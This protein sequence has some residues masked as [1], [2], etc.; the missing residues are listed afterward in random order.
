MKHH[1]GN[2]RGVHIAVRIAGIGITGIVE[3]GGGHIISWSRIR[4]LLYDGASAGLAILGDQRPPVSAMPRVVQR[5]KSELVLRM[6]SAERAVRI[7]RHAGLVEKTRHPR[8]SGPENDAL[9]LEKLA[10]LTS[11]ARTADRWFRSTRN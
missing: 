9:G 1:V 10:L 6:V 2:F 3:S 7:D 4:L 8:R 11:S 5:I